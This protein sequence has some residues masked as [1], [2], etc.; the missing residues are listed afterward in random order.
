MSDWSVFFFAYREGLRSETL[1]FP[2]AE[3]LG[4]FWPYDWVFG[5]VFMLFSVAGPLL[6]I[7]IVSGRRSAVR[8]SQFA[9]LISHFAFRVRQIP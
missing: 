5:S 2:L 8:D 6:L 9:L 4:F 3:T 7:I 1:P